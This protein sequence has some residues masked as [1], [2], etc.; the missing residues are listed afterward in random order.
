MHSSEQATA[1]EKQTKPF[2]VCRN[3]HVIPKERRIERL[4]SGYTI[5]ERSNDSE[6]H[7]WFVVTAFEVAS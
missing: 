7:Y 1:V 4:D 2:V 3:M 6:G 5:R